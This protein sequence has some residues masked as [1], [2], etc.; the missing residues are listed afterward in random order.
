MPRVWF[1]NNCYQRMCVA[2]FM[3]NY[4]INDAV[5]IFQKTQKLT[6]AQ[7]YRLIKLSLKTITAIFHIYGKT[8]ILLQRQIFSKLTMVETN[9]KARKTCSAIILGKLTTTI[10]P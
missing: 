3:K 7:P 6:M 4:Q 5:K 9:E 10:C 2:V 1:K 8:L